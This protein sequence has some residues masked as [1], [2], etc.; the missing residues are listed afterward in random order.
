M[1]NIMTE[2]AETWVPFGYS[3]EEAEGIFRFCTVSGSGALY[4]NLYADGVLAE[5]FRFPEEG[6][7]GD[8]RRMG[9]MLS[10]DGPQYSYTYEADGAE[11]GDPYGRVLS[12]RH[13]WMEETEAAPQTVLTETGRKSA[14]KIKGKVPGAPETAGEEGTSQEACAEAAEAERTHMQQTESGAPEEPGDFRGAVHSTA[15]MWAALFRS[16]VIY[17]LNVRSFT[18]DQSAGLPAAERGGFAGVIAKLPYLK[19][20]GVAAVE[21]M[22][23]YEY[24]ERTELRFGQG[25]ADA[26]G[27]GASGGKQAARANVWGFTARA[28]RFAV[29]EAFGGRRGYEALLEALHGNGMLLIADLYFD[30]TEPYSYVAEVLR[31]W[32]FFYRADGLH[33]IGT[34]PIRELLNDPALRGVKLWY[35]CF[36][37][38]AGAQSCARLPMICGELPGKGKATAESVSGRGMRPAAAGLLP[39]RS[40]EE[41]EKAPRCFVYHSGFQNRMRC[42]LKGDAGSASAAL[43]YL[44]GAAG[45]GSRAVCPE[46]HYMANADGFS[47]WD[48]FCYQERHNLPNGENNQDGPSEN[49]S[50][51]CGEEGPSRKRSVQR[52][53]SRLYRNAAALTLLSRGIPLIYTGDEFGRT[54]GGNNNS[55]CQDNRT[56]WLDWKLCEKNRALYRFVKALIGLRRAHPAFWNPLP[57]ISGGDFRREETGNVFPPL[58]LHGKELW[59]TDFTQETRECCILYGGAGLVCPDGTPEDDF[60]LLCNLYWEPQTFAL[61]RLPEGRFWGKCFDTAEETACGAGEGET[62]WAALSEQER[63][64]LAARSIVLLKSG[65]SAETDGALAGL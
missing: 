49:F 31:T 2:E 47:L 13:A 37:E 5:R 6:R 52:L 59:K 41:R 38:G 61:P 35:D 54:K 12:W 65:G 10:C 55:W 9:L 42:F 20:L 21:L 8:V 22:P 62:G 18:A 39:E 1:G 53:R 50:W 58:S 40:A 26:A 17:R 43:A 11:Y 19:A 4:L 24:D 29:K 46:V 48:V 30:G 44:C 3:Y 60:Y 14:E 28:Q 16:G 51:N 7:Q 36:P 15:D 45:K 64:C 32:A 56:D 25:S 63:I 23:V 57:G 34:V 33:L 27:R